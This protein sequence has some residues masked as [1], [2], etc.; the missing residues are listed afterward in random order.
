MISASRTV[1]S[2]CAFPLS[3]GDELALELQLP[4]PGPA[5]SGAG[6]VVRQ[7][8]GGGEGDVEKHPA[9]LPGGVL[10]QRGLP[11][12]PPAVDQQPPAQEQPAQVQPRPAALPYL[13]VGAARAAIAK[14]GDA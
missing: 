4:V 9:G 14:A 11:H 2:H 3:I 8:R 10:D 6:R 1:F 5:V 12:A 7:A 13:T